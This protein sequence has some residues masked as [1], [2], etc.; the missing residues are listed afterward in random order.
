MK[1]DR[2]KTGII[3]NI[4]KYSVN[5]G[6]GIRTTV[7][8]KGCPLRCKWCANPE[9]QRAELQEVW[10]RSRNEYKT[11]GE[12]K[13]VQQVLDIVLQDKAF[14]EESNGGI[15][16]SGGEM[17]FQPDFSY[18]LLTASKEEGLDTCCE[19]T[20]MAAPDV[21]RRVTEPADH[22]LFDLKHWND[23]AHKKGTGV[24]NALPVENMKQAI[25]D[26]KDVLPRIPVIPDFNDSIED[27]G[28]LARLLRS[29]GADRCQLL[30]FHQFGENKYD[31]IG[32][33]YSYR[34]VPALHREDLE[35]YRQAMSI[36]G[37]DAFF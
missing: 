5:D 32:M 12:Q 7:F 3:F 23:Y 31:L 10:D 36:P 29:I 6:P 35:P 14:Y 11:E 24:S 2:D 21:F 20:G 26:G 18:H 33:D 22:L 9:S 17:L 37:I 34:D 13:S 8:L 25:A 15:T 27:A 16:L 4:Q 19:T 1:A 28:E 30:P